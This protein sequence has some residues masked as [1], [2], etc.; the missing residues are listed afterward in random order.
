MTPPPAGLFTAEVSHLVS[1]KVVMSRMG[2]TT[3]AMVD[4]YEHLLPAMDD[5]AAAELDKLFP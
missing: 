3:M 4:R 5:A 2:W 1:L